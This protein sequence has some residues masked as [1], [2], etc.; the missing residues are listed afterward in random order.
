MH[1]KDSGMFAHLFWKC[2]VIYSFTYMHSELEEIQLWIKG[3]A[4]ESVV[5]LGM[6]S[7]LLHKPLCS[8]N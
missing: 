5:L 1:L 2:K 3:G 7:S 6:C 8:Q 4:T